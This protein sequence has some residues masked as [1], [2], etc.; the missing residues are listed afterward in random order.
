MKESPMLHLAGP[1]FGACAR[2]SNAVGECGV[3]QAARAGLGGEW[4][5]TFG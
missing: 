5:P 1:A 3:I 2:G 4:C